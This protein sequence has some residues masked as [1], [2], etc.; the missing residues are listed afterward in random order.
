[1]CLCVCVCGGG[2]GAT[3]CCN[4]CLLVAV[5]LVVSSKLDISTAMS[6]V[7]RTATSQGKGLTPRFFGRQNTSISRSQ[8][9]VGSIVGGH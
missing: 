3:R 6:D 4:G 8:L 7:A 9:P 2:G 1:M 5:Y